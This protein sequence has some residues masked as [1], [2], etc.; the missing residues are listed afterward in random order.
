MTLPRSIA[1]QYYHALN[2]A[3]PQEYFCL[4]GGRHVHHPSSVLVEASDHPGKDIRPVC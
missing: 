4:F 1:Y 3:I 2:R